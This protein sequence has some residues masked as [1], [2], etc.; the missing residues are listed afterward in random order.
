MYFFIKKLTDEIIQKTTLECLNQ[1]LF[2]Q[3][4]D[5]FFFHADGTGNFFI[6]LVYSNICNGV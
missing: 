2:P 6:Q 3:F 4:V 5:A 1:I